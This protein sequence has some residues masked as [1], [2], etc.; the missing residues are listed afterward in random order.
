MPDLYQ[1]IKAQ[2]A[3]CK[4]AK[5]V[6]AYSGGL[7]SQV[8][9][10]LLSKVCTELNLPLQ[11]VHIHHGL[12]P[13]ADNWAT[14]C[15]QQSQQRQIPFSLC[16]VHLLKD[17]NIEQ[18]ARDARYQA[19]A[20]F[21]DSADT[22]LLTAHHADDQLETI[23][24]ALKRGAGLSGLAG[25]P[26]LRTFAA[27]QLLRPL[28]AVSRAQL[29][30]YAVAEQL[31]WVEDESNLNVDFDRNFLRQ[32]I[33]PLLQQRWPSITKT[34]ARSAQHLQHALVLSDAY[35]DQA[36]A[37]CLENTRLDLPTLATYPELQQDLVLRRWLAKF[38]FNPS[39]SWLNTLK[40]DVIA[41]RDDA[42]PLLTLEQ[43][44]IRRYQQQLYV[45]MPS[46]SITPGIYTTVKV[47]DN[48]SLA[49]GL[50]CWHLSKTA[51]ALP[52]AST[53]EDYDIAF[54]LLSA[55]FKPVG[56][57]SKPLKQWF[58]LWKVPP[59]QR[60]HIPLLMQQGRIQAVLGYGSACAEEQ[61][62]AWISW[63]PTEVE[64]G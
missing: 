52:V 62:A 24:L 38:G 20:Q 60:P 39:T 12:S 5:L 50:I 26:T 56:K 42:V 7:D 47:G 55:P 13:Q 8:L 54:G 10:H 41:A 21:I 22:L 44:Q 19:L 64:L 51:L 53:V 34:A 57:P 17:N 35:T 27:G 15:R 16:H 11:A 25:I 59:W 28:L 46:S 48:A 31:S 63:Q 6:L 58:K 9:L 61:A 43:A 29:Q 49:Q 40:H 14:F 32:H 45:L 36:L 1:V 2:I 18:Q 33:T 37:A 3:P 23:L 30:H 4:P